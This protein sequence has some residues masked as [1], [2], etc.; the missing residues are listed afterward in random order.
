LNS[1]GEGEGRISLTGK[2]TVDS[3]AKTLSLEDFGTAPVVLK[4]VKRKTS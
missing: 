3:S 4:N 1:K 2:V